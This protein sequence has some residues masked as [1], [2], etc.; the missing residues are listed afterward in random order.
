MALAH[1]PKII[2]DGLVLCL[3]AGNTKSYPGSGTTWTD[4]SGNGNNGTLNNM[5][6]VNL[7]SANGGN[8]T[9]DATNEFVRVLDNDSLDFG[10]GDFT[11]SLWFKR[12]TNETGN[13]RLISKGASTDNANVENA[14]FAFYG[15]DSGLALTVNA[16]ATRTGPAPN[17]SIS[18]DTWTNAILVMERGVNMRSYKN[19]VPIGTNTAPAG[20][21]SG[22]SNLI[23]GAHAD[24]AG[25][26]WSG[27]IAQVFIYNKALTAQEIQ[28]NYNA[29]KGRYTT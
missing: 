15:S 3:D 14:G 10:T 22:T 25:L 5:D 19:A 11:V 6:G 24:G 23:I 1:S 2:T 26:Y 18:L 21:V 17:I 27:N 9:F 8:L 29:L 13:L 16:T 12:S 4:L 7:D 28:Q 20:S